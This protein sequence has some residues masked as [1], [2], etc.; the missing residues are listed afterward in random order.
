MSDSTDSLKIEFRVLWFCGFYFSFRV[1]CTGKTVHSMA[2]SSLSVE[3]VG[4]GVQILT[5]PEG[6]VWHTCQ[7]PKLFVRSAYVAFY[8]QF[9]SGKQHGRKVTALGTPGIG[10]SAAGMYFLHRAL[11]E[12]KKVL[13]R[14]FRVNRYHVYDGDSKTVIR[15]DS[16]SVDDLLDDPEVL[17]ICDGISPPF[18]K[19]TVLLITSPK[20]DVWWAFSKETGMVRYLPHPT[21]E[22]MHLMRKHCFSEMAVEDMLDGIRVFGPNPRAVFIHHLKK[23]WTELTLTNII[24]NEG[25]AV[26]LKA[27]QL[28]E[29]GKDDP[30]HRLIAIKATADFLDGGREFCS[31]FVADEIYKHLEESNRE[32][33]YSWLAVTGG[34][35]NPLIAVM[36]GTLFERASLT[37]LAEGGLFK[38]RNLL[39]GDDE[40]IEFP[41]M[42]VENWPPSEW[43]SLRPGVLFRAPHEK[44]TAIDAISVNDSSLR[45]YNA[46]INTD[47]SV[48][49]LD[50]TQ[51]H[52][53]VKLREGFAAKP[54]ISCE[55]F[56]L[57][58]DDQ[59]GKMKKLTKSKF[60]WSPPSEKVKSPVVPSDMVKAQ[61]KKYWKFSAVLI[62][63]NN[64]RSFSTLRSVLRYC[65]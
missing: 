47:H 4:G 30:C 50:A 42:A 57:L 44:Y 34:I 65:L 11:K 17:L 26:L 31:D 16:S 61:Q 48:L 22:E 25:A 24:S 35:K 13:Y 52:G 20:R 51:K 14:D 19:C 53:L 43:A 63:F 39:T 2:S 58:P 64:K 8:E 37:I 15:L 7:H 28:N 49:M 46:T 23:N 10:K 5:L 12:N 21:V 29:S 33:L 55:H 38:T 1:I 32:A 9:L 56:M 40:D 3:D 60:K 54:G 27:S 59:F 41:K 62:P 6:E 45:T 36:R 18:A